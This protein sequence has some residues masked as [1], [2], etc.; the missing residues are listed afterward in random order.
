MSAPKD[1]ECRRMIF[2]WR[3][4]GECKTMIFLWRS[5][6]ECRDVTG[7]PEDVNKPIYTL[8]LV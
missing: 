7:H 3:S 2:M 6:G 5:A 4:V 1:G 8:T